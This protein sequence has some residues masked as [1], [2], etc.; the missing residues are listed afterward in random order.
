MKGLVNYVKEAYAELL[1]KVSWPTFKELQSS[2]ILVMVASLCFAIVVLAM[3]VSFEFLM[4]KIYNFL[5]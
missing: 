3:D 5:Y 1:H 2:T 4:K